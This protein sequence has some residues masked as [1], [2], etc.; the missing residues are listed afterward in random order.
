ME[1]PKNVSTLPNELLASPAPN[2]S[3]VPRRFMLT[4][5]LLGMLPMLAGCASWPWQEKPQ[6]ERPR[7]VTEWMEKS[8]RPKF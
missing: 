5:L 6:E 2:V 8:E 4:G 1:T 3:Q 7:T